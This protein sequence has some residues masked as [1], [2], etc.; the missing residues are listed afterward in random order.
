MSDG[1]AAYEYDPNGNLIFKT[2]DGG[3]T[4]YGYDY[5]DRLISATTLGVPAGAWVE[6][7][8]VASFLAIT[9]CWFL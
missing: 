4:A 7:A 5:G 9:P 2:T 8:S 1:N 6:S 3:T